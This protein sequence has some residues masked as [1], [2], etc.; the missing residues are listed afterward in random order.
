VKSIR[1]HMN[2]EAFAL[3]H[4]GIQEK[5]LKKMCNTI[6]VENIE[7]L[8]YETIPDD[9]RLKEKLNLPNALSEHEF[10]NLLQDFSNKNKIFKKKIMY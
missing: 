2:T 6:G 7:A 10:L 5:D 8:I 1:L 3:R 4:I 9:I